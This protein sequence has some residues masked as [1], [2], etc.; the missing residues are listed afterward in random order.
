MKVSAEHRPPERLVAA[1]VVF[2]RA[3]IDVKHHEQRH[4]DAGDDAA[5]KQRADRD[6][7]HH[8]VDHER[9]RRRDDRPERRG[10]GGDADGELGRV[11]VILHRLDLDRAE[12]GGIRDRGARHA[13]EDHR[14]DDVH[15]RE[16][17]AHP[18]RERHREIVDAVGDAGR[19]HQVAGEDEERH[20]EQRKRVDAACHAMQD[21]EVRQTCDEMRVD[22]R[23]ARERDENRHAG[24]QAPQ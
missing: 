1:H 23:R 11:A 18:A 15:V 24:E 14:A 19:V 21:H 6:V 22:E 2:A 5:E 20:R 12:T 8:S 3:V 13:G 9:Q 16:P 10:C 4:H 7:R 17:A